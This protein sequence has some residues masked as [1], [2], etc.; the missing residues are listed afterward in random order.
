MQIKEYTLEYTVVLTLKSLIQGCSLM[1]YNNDNDQRK[2]L[3][4]DGLYISN[5]RWFANLIVGL[6]DK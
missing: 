3:I 1:V 6:E 4:E 5:L 2:S